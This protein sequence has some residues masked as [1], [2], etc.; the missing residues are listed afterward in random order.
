M[1][2]IISA[3]FLSIWTYDTFRM[4]S[5]PENL[6]IKAAKSL[7]SLIIKLTNSNENRIMY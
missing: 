2:E 5:L 7:H 3:K 6:I 4:E 1:L